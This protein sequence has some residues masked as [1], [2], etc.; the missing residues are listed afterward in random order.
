YVETAAD[1]LTAAGAAQPAERLEPELVGLSAGVARPTPWDL[2]QRTLPGRGP[3]GVF[4][5][6]ARNDPALPAFADFWASFK[7]LAGYSARALDFVLRE[8]LDLAAYRFDAWLTSLAHVRLDA[9]RT[10]NP[11]AGIVFGAYGWLEEVRPQPQRPSDG[12]VH[13][14]SLAHA[15]TAAVLR[16]GYLTHRG[17]AQGVMAVD[18][19]S[20][21]V[22]LGPRL[23]GGL[24]TGQPRAALLGYR[25]ER[26]LHD[27]HGDGRYDQAIGKLRSVVPLDGAPTNGSGTTE[28][29]AATNVV[30]GL[31]LL[32]KVRADPDFLGKQGLPPRGDAVRDAVENA[33]G[34]LD[35]ALDSVADL[36]L[37]ESVHQLVRGNTIRAGATLDAIA[38]GDA[39]PPELDVVQ[40]PRAGTALTHRLLAIAASKAAA[41]WTNTPR[42]QA[43]PR[44]NA[45]AAALLG[46]PARVHVRARFL[47]AAGAE[48]ATVEFGLDKLTV[49]PLDLLALPEGNGLTG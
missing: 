4:L 11:N 17:D 43:E 31:A 6:G 3:V 16:S 48:L 22:R 24:R 15:S 2:L 42:A 7:R 25:F 30:D 47:D 37:A 34:R 1:L 33:V 8:V 14:P 40:T 18:L 45:F 9:L 35:D 46:A 27:L 23:L 28:S 38:R 13:A 32:R 20:D 39:P 12:Y 49:A 5:D 29:I 21:R 19:S 10:A 44:L 36:T 26:F 41:G